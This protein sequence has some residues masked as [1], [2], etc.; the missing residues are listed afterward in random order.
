MF[1]GPVKSI[2]APKKLFIPALL[3]LATILN[4]SV[5]F[6]QSSGPDLGSLIPSVFSNPSSLMTFVIELVLGLGLG[7]F[8]AKSIKYVLAIIGIFV[9]G[10]ALNVWTA[11][12]LGTSIPFSSLGPDWSKIYPVLLS[13]IYVLGLTTVLPITLGFIIG[14]VMAVMK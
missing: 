12:N 6:A 2:T 4:V 1:L 3:I 7:Y 10:V 9:V 11:P 14:I 5:V 13:I 8:S